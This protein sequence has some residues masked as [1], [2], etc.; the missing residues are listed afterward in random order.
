VK[1]LN[2]LKRRSVFQVGVAYT[3]VAWL[4]IQVSDIILP[5]FS[6]PDWSLKAI[7]LLALVGFPITLLSTWFFNLTPDGVRRADENLT[8]DEDSA[9]PK[10]ALNYIIISVLTA[11]VFLFALDKFYFTS[12]LI[13]ASEP[14]QHSIAVLPFKNLSG[15]DANMPF[16][17]GIHDDLLTQISKIGALRTI[18]RTSVMPYADTQLS[19]PQIAAELGVTTVLEGGVQRIGDRIRVNA[20]LID[21]KTDTHLW[22]ETYDRQLSAANIF[23]IQSEIAHAIAAALSATLSDN[24]QQALNVIPTRN[25]EAY[26]AYSAARASM[27][28]MSGEDISR[29]VSQFTLATE[30]DPEFAA[31]WAGLCQAHLSLYSTDSNREDFES[32]ESACETALKLDDTRVEVHVALGTLYRYFGQ[33]SKAEVS[34]QR[35]T[36]AKAQRALEYALVLDGV[37]SDALI[38]LGQVLAR[39][40]RLDEAEQKLLLAEE[41]EP[42]SWYAQNSLYS[43]YY[44]YSDRP[45][46]FE[47]AARHATTSASLRPELASSWNNL[48][49]SNFM[50]GRYELAAEAWQESIRLQPNRT[51]YTNT[52]LALFYSGKYREAAEMQRKAIALAP[53]DYRALGR[54]ADALRFVEGYEAEVE[55]AYTQAVKLAGNLLEINGRDWRTLGQLGLYQFHIDQVDAARESIDNALRLSERNA[56]TLYY[57]A[58][59]QTLSGQHDEALDTLSEAI[60]KD[61]DYRHLISIDPEFES[62]SADP[63]FQDLLTDQN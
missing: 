31:A 34:L 36:Y 13:P 28:S 41:L 27:D 38:E 2:E 37:E 15:D 17:Y 58:Q 4:L 50:L 45:N 11:A 48:G 16:A 23:A 24:E 19:I 40:G 57:L 9:F 44:T 51:G 32:A 21:G 30:I 49:S 55:E 43:F 7:I 62:L 20:Q 42:A 29:A 59:I 60:S 6:A 46:R 39:Q 54:K 14:S 10:G 61:A 47:L 3:V 26:E 56:E 53:N 63:R 8:H 12:S 5:T 18:S 22:A 35:A 1:F 33:Y 25:L 52:G